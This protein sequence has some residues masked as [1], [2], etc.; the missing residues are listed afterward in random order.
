MLEPLEDFEHQGETILASR[1]GYRITRRFIRGI[2]GRIFDNPARVFDESI[3]K[4]ETQDMA[5]YIDGIKN[6]CEAQQRVAQAY[7]DD[8]SVEEA[9]PPLKAMLYIMATGDYQGRDAHDPDVRALFTRESLLA[10]DWYRARLDARQQRDIALWQRHVA[11]LDKGVDPRLLAEPR[12][13]QELADRRVIAQRRLEE[14]QTDAY[15]ATL[16]GTIG[17]EPDLVAG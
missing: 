5:A 14:V 8:G 16:V 7:L 2:F 12:F 1:L 10:S 17:T 3:L 11:Y 13:A 4:P 6:I 9:C 15:R